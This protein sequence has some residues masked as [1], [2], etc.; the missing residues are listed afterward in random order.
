MGLHRDTQDVAYYAGP[1][2]RHRK[3]TVGMHRA[4]SSRQGKQTWL[5]QGKRRARRA[6]SELE[7]LNDR[8]VGGR[9]PGCGSKFRA[10]GLVTAMTFR[11]LSG[12]QVAKSC[13]GSDDGGKGRHDRCDGDL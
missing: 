8:G 10:G 7:G 4:P 3:E 13:G 9:T 5:H 12:T 11:E 2:G 1:I 6:V